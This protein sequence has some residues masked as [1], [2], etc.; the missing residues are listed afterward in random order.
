MG[1][2]HSGKDELHLDPKGNRLTPKI[3]KSGKTWIWRARVNGTPCVITIG[4]FPAIGLSDARIC[5]GQIIADHAQGIDVYCK[6]GV[7]AKNAHASAK[8]NAVTCQEAWDRYIA[9][10][11]AGTNVHGE[12]ENKPCK[13]A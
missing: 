3:T 11:K 12:S 2:K 8:P 10:L 5:A 13:E 1:L 9:G 7:G 6:Y 4:R